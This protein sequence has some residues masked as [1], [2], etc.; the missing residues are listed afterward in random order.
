MTICI[1]FHFG[2]Y[3]LFI[4][5][6]RTVFGSPTIYHKDD[7]VKII[8]TGIG[9]ITGAGLLKL[10]DNVKSRISSQQISHT[11][12]I[13]EIINSEREKIRYQYQSNLEKEQIEKWIT[14]TSWF[15][16]YCT[17]Q[18]WQVILPLALVSGSLE[19][20]LYLTEPPIA[21]IILTS[22]AGLQVAKDYELKLNKNLKP[23]LDFRDFDEHL[24]YHISLSA[25]IIQ[26]ASKKY[27]TIS[28]KMIYGFHTID[29]KIEISDIIELK[30]EQENNNSID[31]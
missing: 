7:S 15:F 31:S 23:L 8:N 4:A 24:G 6:T 1:C 11:D 27:N 19:N 25:K 9:L 12:N 10:L 22:E 14:E 21:S 13:M 26:S 18:D 2:E 30:N 20:E 16:T 5:D 3:I 17:L 28:S 29:G